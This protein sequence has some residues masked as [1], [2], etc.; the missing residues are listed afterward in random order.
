MATMK[1][2]VNKVIWWFTHYTPVSTEAG[3]NVKGLLKGALFVVLACAAADI[4]NEFLIS[5]PLKIYLASLVVVLALIAAALWK[6]N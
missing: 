3:V 6:S 1:A 5:I 2:T 4:I